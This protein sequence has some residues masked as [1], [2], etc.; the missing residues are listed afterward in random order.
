MPSA[1]LI[2]LLELVVGVAL[3]VVFTVA[4][5]EALL[6]GPTGQEQARAQGSVEEEGR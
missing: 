1:R 2:P 6:G 3:V 4:G 5:L